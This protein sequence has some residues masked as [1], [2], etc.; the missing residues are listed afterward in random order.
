[1]AGVQLSERKELPNALP[2]QPFR[3][4]LAPARAPDKVKVMEAKGDWRGVLRELGAAER[5]ADATVAAAAAAAGTAEV[6]PRPEPMTVYMYTACITA[7]S[8]CKRW[9]EALGLLDRMLAAAAAAGEGGGGLT[10]NLNTM[11][12]V[13]TACGR[14]GQGK[15]ALEVNLSV[16]R[17]A[18]LFTARS[19]DQSLIA[20]VLF[21]DA[22]RRPP[23]DA[24]WCLLPTRVISR[25]LGVNR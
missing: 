25:W 17:E 15:A 20:A 4:L 10:P 14:C 23:R 1:M 16:L 18:A 7:M 24:C 11:S 19:V 5:R 2:P 21:W 12:A 3:P 9:K 22:L 8:K 6:P 13:I